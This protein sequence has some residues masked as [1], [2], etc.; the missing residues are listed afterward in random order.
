MS[1]GVTLIQ[2]FGGHVSAAMHGSVGSG[3][4]APPL[5][6]PPLAVVAPAVPPAL[7][8]SAEPAEANGAAPPAPA[9]LLAP[10]APAPLLA[11]PMPVPKP[12]LPRA[13]APAPAPVPPQPQANRPMSRGL[14]SQDDLICCDEA[15][16][17][18]RTADAQQRNKPVQ[19]RG[20]KKRVSESVQP[21]CALALGREARA[22]RTWGTVN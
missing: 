20:H 10:P 15:P 5:P 13:C 4:G 21:A 1:C 7:P 17:R 9:P 3:S 16:A 12:P 14:S 19:C 2:V 11:P 18:R 8:P 22:E 6:P